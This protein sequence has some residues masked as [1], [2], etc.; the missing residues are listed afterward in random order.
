MEFVEDWDYTPGTGMQ[1]K[2]IISYLYGTITMHISAAGTSR[3]LAILYLPKTVW[4][5]EH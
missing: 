2:K 5:E 3:I 1:V 4:M